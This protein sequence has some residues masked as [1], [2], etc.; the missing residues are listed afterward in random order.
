MGILRTMARIRTIKPEF[1][2][3]ESMGRLSRDARLLFVLMWTIAD[4]EGRLR[5]SSKFLC[6]QLFPYDDDVRESI[7]SWV[8]E[9]AAEECIVR[10][11]VNDSQYVQ[12]VEWKQHQK[13]DR[14]TKSRFPDPPCVKSSMVPREASRALDEPS[15][16]TREPST[17]PR[18]GKERKGEEGSR[19]E[20]KGEDGKAPTA[21]PSPIPDDQEVFIFPKRDGTDWELP[22][23]EYQELRN[24]FPALDVDTE[25]RK[26]S[27]WLRK[28][29]ARQKANI[30]RFLVNWLSR[31]ATD[32]LNKSPPKKS[33]QELVE[34]YRRHLIA[35]GAFDAE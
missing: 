15:T 11:T 13:I 34:D 14:P 18:P 4:D 31:A 8:D 7:D 10:Y 24:T 19:Q 12:I 35:Q 22:S 33:N 29:P 6:G 3:S 1:P 26:A 9:L 23:S 17:S 27:L 16:D 32:A 25:L 2:Q 20:S 21:K 28:N 5:G 30:S